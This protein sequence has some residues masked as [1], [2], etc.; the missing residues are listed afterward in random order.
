MTLKRPLLIGAVGLKDT[1]KSTMLSFLAE[2]FYDDDILCKSFFCDKQP[3]IELT[4][5]FK[6]HSP[7][8]L[9]KF[10]GNIILIPRVIE[11]SVVL[12]DNIKE[13]DASV[14]TSLGGILINVTRNI[15]D[16]NIGRQSTQHRYPNEEE[17]WI[18]KYRYDYHLTSFEESLRRLKFDTTIAYEHLKETTKFKSHLA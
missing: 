6:E 8:N 12:V 17:K 18:S 16:N 9:T 15:Y 5:Y 14:I 11:H 2:N 1:G 3:S 7:Y 13:I 4:E 10:L